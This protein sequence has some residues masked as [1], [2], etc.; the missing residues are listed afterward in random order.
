MKKKWKLI[1]QIALARSSNLAKIQ[2]RFWIRNFSIER[3]KK[4]KSCKECRRFLAEFLWSERLFVLSLV[5]LKTTHKLFTFSN[6]F[7]SLKF[8]SSKVLSCTLCVQFA[9]VVSVA[10]SVLSDASAIERV[11][12]DR[13]CGRHHCCEIIIYANSPLIITPLI[14]PNHHCPIAP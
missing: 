4:Q 7:L 14:A 9:S 6:W 3:G 8:T 11:N 1:S 5:P 12:G 13:C 10:F 2:I